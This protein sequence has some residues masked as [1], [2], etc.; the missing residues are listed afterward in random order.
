[1]A[2]LQKILGTPLFYNSFQYLV[3]EKIF[4]QALVD[5]FIQPKN[6]DVI[7]DIGCGTGSY[8]GYMK[9]LDIK[10]YGFDFNPQYIEFAKKTYKDS[11]NALFF[12]DNINQNNLPDLPK[13]DKILCM[14]VQHHLANEELDNLY[15]LIKAMMKPSGE[16]ITMDPCIYQNMN[17]LEWLLCRYDRGQF[18]RS[19]PDYTNLLEKI[20]KIQTKGSFILG[21]TPSRAFVSV[22]T[23]K[24]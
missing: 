23:L 15:A 12:C 5:R 16:I 14:G 7:L 4:R 24:H 3:G 20:F 13:F 17:I 21:K 11:N 2:L 9:Q 18:V 10:Y 1:M 8:F 6:G 22:S 19:E